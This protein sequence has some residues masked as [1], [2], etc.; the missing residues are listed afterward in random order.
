VFLYWVFLTHQEIYY[1]C[2]H[3]NKLI[4]DEITSDSTAVKGI[5]KGNQGL[6][7][8]LTVEG[9]PLAAGALPAPKAGSPEGQKAL[10][11]SLAG[12][13][14]AAPKK[15]AKKEGTQ[16]EEAAPK[17][18]VEQLAF[19]YITFRLSERLCFPGE[20]KAVHGYIFIFQGQKLPAPYQSIWAHPRQKW[21]PHS[22]LRAQDFE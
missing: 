19:D 22:A 13:L 16:V 9:G 1:Y 3:G 17:S 21:A 6:V 18:F 10:L 12:G 2:N 5:D 15:K 8:V 11:E 7:E 4:N 20:I 14:Q